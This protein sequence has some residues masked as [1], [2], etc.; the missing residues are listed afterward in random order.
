MD[1]IIPIIELESLSQK[2]RKKIIARSHL[3]L[4]QILEEVIRPMARDIE[5]RGF[6]ALRE[7]SLRYDRFFPSPLVL[8]REDLRIAYSHYKQK[9]PHE[10]K[11][12][13]EALENIKAFH[14]AQKLT[15]VRVNVAQNSLGFTFIPFDHVALYVPGGK[16]LYPSTVLMGVVPAKIAGVAEVSVF[17]PPSETGVVSEVVQAVAYLA[18]ADR[19]V[20]LGGAQAIIAAALGIEEISLAAADFVYGP[21]NIYVAAA[22]VYAFSRLWCGIDSFAGPSEVIIIADSS[23]NPHYVAHDLLAQAEHDEQASA[24]LLTNDRQLAQACLEEIRKALAERGERSHITE[25]AIRNN[26]KI[27][28]VKDLNEALDFVHEYAPEHLEIMAE[29]DMEILSRVRAAGSI[30]L[31]PYSPVAA[32]DYYTGTNHI[33]PTGG[34]CRFAS[35][36]STHT[37]Y[38][39]ISWQKV[40]EAGLRQAAPAIAL[41]SRVEGLFAEHGYSV[42][43]RFDDLKKELWYGNPPSL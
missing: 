8:T 39:R 2:E 16:A 4:D 18:G 29:N 37:F 28:L 10:I 31:G 38:R 36:V 3:D 33:L 42:L 25:K 20:Q 6:A 11:A 1:E 7:I 41:M 22:K 12:F 32:G 27:F 43:A 14:E 15:P 23:A 9:F 17:S 30:F 5:E 13:L 26:G 34:A 21:G 24:I 19:I 35:G 40:S